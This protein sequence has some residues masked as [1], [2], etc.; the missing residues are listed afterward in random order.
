MRN[1]W[2]P[3]LVG[4]FALALLALCITGIAQAATGVAQVTWTNPTTYT[5]GSPLAT[6]EITGYNVTCTFRVTGTTSTVPCGGFSP[7]TLTGSLTSTQT[8]LTY[9]AAGGEA[10]FTLVVKVGAALSDPS[11]TT[12]ASCKTFAALRPSKA[13]GVTVV[14]TVATNAQGQTVL[15]L[16]EN[17]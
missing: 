5:D 17:N 11:D 3:R 10:C 7:A 8:T 6:A 14:V 15:R 4:G 13:T 9:P 2:T 16:V 12:A 1:L